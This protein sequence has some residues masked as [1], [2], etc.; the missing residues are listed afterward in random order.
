MGCE[1]YVAQRVIEREYACRQRGIFELVR[2][3]G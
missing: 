2:T 1:K 3:V